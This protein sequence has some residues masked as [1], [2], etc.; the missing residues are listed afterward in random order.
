MLSLAVQLFAADR[1]DVL[2][3]VGA[4]GDA[5]YAERFK[6]WSEAW[7]QACMRAQVGCQVI[8]LDGAEDGDKDAVRQAITAAATSGTQPLWLVLI[9]H[10]TFDGRAAKFNL[11]GFDVAAEELASWLEACTRPVVLLN[12]A[13]ASAP[14]L[15]TLSRPGRVVIS[16]TKSGRENHATRF[17]GFVAET[18][19]TNG[20]ALADLDQDGQVSVLEVF[21]SAA[22]A[23]EA[24]Y[25]AEGLIATE[26]PL[27]DDNGDGRGT[28]ADWFRGVW[29]VKAATDGATVDGIRAHQIHLLPSAAER[30][31][32][33][34][35]Q[36][37]RDQLEQELAVLRRAKATLA[38]DE[39][40]RRLEA[41]MQKLAAIYQRAAKNEKQ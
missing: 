29:A 1:Q 4:P 13:P 11:R 9:G 31:L 38:E 32:S 21:L 14:F 18:L 27:I 8:G 36:K 16:A 12:T 39:Y 41:I 25:K 20:A 5:E 17:G 10:G 3:V 28:R 40:Y 23:V 7:R 15:T 2:V 30:Q 6:T 22:R 26:H 34:D 19:A 37:A 35:D 24:S 33:G